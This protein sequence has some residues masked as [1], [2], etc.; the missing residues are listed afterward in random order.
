MRAKMIIAL[1]GVE[2]EV[3]NESINSIKTE[4]IHNCPYDVINDVYVMKRS[5]MIKIR[6][7]SI[8]MAEKIKADWPSLFYFS[9][10]HRNIEEYRCTIVPHVHVMLLVHTN[11]KGLPSKKIR[12]SVA[13][14][15]NQAIHTANAQ[16]WRKKMIKDTVFDKQAKAQ[17]KMI[18]LSMK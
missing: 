15:Q 4:I 14:A 18:N 8:D 17:S 5:N 13:N 2:Q 12:M 3:L 1:K 9:I 11:P 16:T 7:R 10:P 6:L